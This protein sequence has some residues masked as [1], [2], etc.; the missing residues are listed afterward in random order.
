MARQIDT[1]FLLIRAWPSKRSFNFFELQR[2][3]QRARDVVKSWSN[4]V[5]SVPHQ[6]Y[7]NDHNVPS[8]TSVFIAKVL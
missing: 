1:L 7:T 2:P 4:P 8:M 3:V 6:E 5:F